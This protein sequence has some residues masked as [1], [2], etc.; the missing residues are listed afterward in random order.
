MGTAADKGRLLEQRVAEF[1]RSN[2]YA[3]TCNEIVEGR[4]GSRHEIDVLAEKSDALTT[5][6]VAIECK[7]WQTP[8]EKDVVSKLHY[9]LG[10]SGFNKGI[11]VSLAGARSGAVTTASDLGIELWGP[12]ELR[13]HLGDASVADL[14][15]ST[16][17]ANTTVSWGYKFG[18]AASAAEKMIRSSGKG[19]LNLRKLEEFVW[20]LPLWVPAYCIK[21]TVAQPEVK[22]FK[23]RLRSATIV[24]LYESYSG[25]FL[26]RAN[27]S[28]EQIDIE[29]RS[30]LRP[31]L[32]DTKIH[33]T[34][35]KTEQA[36]QKVSTPTAKERHAANLARLGIPTPCASVSI[37][38][39][40]TVHLPYFVG[41]LGTPSGQRVVA[42]DGRNGHISDRMTDML[43]SNL[44]VMRDQLA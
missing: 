13:K 42:V 24:N 33:T 29:S 26:A 27:G 28:W 39:T 20:F 6:R 22:R 31:L 44:A 37:D 17:S 10:D 15:V 1:F 25:K 35:R 4:S 43:T 8:I 3:A 11:I 23:T 30:S 5:Y 21:L 19:R 14:N 12:E 7:A 41:I 36:Y 32:K 38:S 2:G 40:S 16:S 18:V 34:I 9:I